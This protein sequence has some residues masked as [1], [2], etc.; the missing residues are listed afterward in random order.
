[1]IPFGAGSGSRMD[2]WNRWPSVWISSVPSQQWML[3]RMLERP[4]P[5][6]VKPRLADRYCRG[7]S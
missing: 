7:A 5:C 3:L 2:T 4:M 6:S 1:M